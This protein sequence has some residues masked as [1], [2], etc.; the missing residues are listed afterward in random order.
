[1]KTANLEVAKWTGTV[2][3][4][5]PIPLPLV[6]D[7]DEGIERIN[8]DQAEGEP[9]KIKGTRLIRDL[10]APCL[11]CVD[12]WHVDGLPE[13]VAFESFPGTPREASMKLAMWIIGQVMSVYNGESGEL[14]PTPPEAS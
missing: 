4:L 9:N 2:D 6:L 5:D 12:K 7:I 1:M 10:L 13:H 14:D 8:A 11:A 3:L